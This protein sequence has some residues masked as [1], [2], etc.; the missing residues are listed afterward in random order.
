MKLYRYILNM[1]NYVFYRLY[2]SRIFILP[3]Q[4]PLFKTVPFISILLVMEFFILFKLV[5]IIYILKLGVNMQNTYFIFLVMMFLSAVLNIYYY[6]NNN[7]Y[8]LILEKF[9]LE[10]EKGQKNKDIKAVAFVSLLVAAIII[11]NSIVKAMTS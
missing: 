4:K 6:Q 8:I 5:Q 3:G 1:H 10:D 9:A 2:Y 7:K 11:L